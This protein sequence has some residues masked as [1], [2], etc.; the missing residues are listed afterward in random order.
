MQIKVFHAVSGVTTL[1]DVNAQTWGELKNILINNNLE[2]NSFVASESINKTTLESDDAK[3]PQENFIL[4]LRQKDTKAGSLSRDELKKILLEDNNDFKHYLKEIGI[5]WTIT[6]TIDLNNLYQVFLDECDENK[7]EDLEEEIN[8]NPIVII[9]DIIDEL[10][11][12]KEIIENGDNNSTKTNE[13]LLS[14]RKEF[15]RFMATVH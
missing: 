12:L 4:F 14:L 11:N 5:N 1:E 9:D 15:E 10:E 2:V 3:I 13:E 6:S 8:N 7:D